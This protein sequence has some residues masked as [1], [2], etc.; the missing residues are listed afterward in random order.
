MKL[1]LSLEFRIVENLLENE[2]WT[3]RATQ[4]EFESKFTQSRN[5]Q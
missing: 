2:F 4:N 5:S 3:S 1:V